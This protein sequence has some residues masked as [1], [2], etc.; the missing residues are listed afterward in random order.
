MVAMDPNGI[1]FQRAKYEA[2][3]YG[4]DEW[5]FLRELV[6]NSRDAGATSVSFTFQQHGDRET[7]TCF[8]DGT[9]MSRDAMESY[10]LKLYSSSKE[11]PTDEAQEQLGF[12]G[13][14]F[15]SVLRFKPRLIEVCSRHQGTETAIRILPS[16]HDIDEIEPV[17]ASKLPQGTRIV[18]TRSLSGSD[19]RTLIRK[20]LR[21]YARFIEACPVHHGKNN[22]PS[23][24]L[25]FNGETL[26]EPFHQKKDLVFTRESTWKCSIYSSRQA[27]FQIYHGGLLIHSCSRIDEVFVNRTSPPLIFNPGIRLSLDHATPLMDRKTIFEDPAT[28]AILEIVDQAC[29][30]I[31]DQMISSRY[32]LGIRT[33]KARFQ[34]VFSYGVLC[35]F[36]LVALFIAGM[37][38][39]H[40]TAALPSSPMNTQDVTSI[41][42]TPSDTPRE[43]EHRWS[44]TYRIRGT[45]LNDPVLFTLGLLDQNN[46]KPRAIPAWSEM[47]SHPPSELHTEDQFIDLEL[48]VRPTQK[49]F[50][51]PAPPGYI[52]LPNSPITLSG[53]PF[54]SIRWDGQCSAYAL[55]SMDGVLKYTLQKA[56][57]SDPVPPV[58]EYKPQKSLF[59]IPELD[60]FVQ[61]TQP[62]S[63]S[64]KLRATNLLFQ[65]YFHYNPI[66]STQP[67]TGQTASWPKQL[68]ESGRGVCD[69]INGLGALILTRL[70][71]KHQLQYGIVGMA[72]RAEPD[73]HAWIVRGS[74][75]N[76]IIDF[77]AVLDPSQPDLS[78][79][80]EAEQ[81]NTPP[82]T[83][84]ARTQ[85]KTS[86][87]SQYVFSYA[88]TCSLIV[89]FLAAAFLF[90]KRRKKKS[91][92]DTPP[93][94]LADMIRY[95]LEHPASDPLLLKLRPFFT[96]LSGKRLCLNDF[97]RLSPNRFILLNPK[98]APLLKGIHPGIH[99][100]DETH[101]FFSA[102]RGFLPDLFQLTGAIDSQN[103]HEALK[104]IFRNLAPGSELVVLE[105]EKGF[106]TFKLPLSSAG[107]GNTQ[108]VLGSLSLPASVRQST[109]S[110]RQIADFLH[111]LIQRVEG[112]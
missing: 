50:R 77:T 19:P 88:L 112:D 45:R 73:L 104:N 103:T 57:I 1:F 33:L 97:F 14:G 60:S 22:R 110:R 100:M 101:P 2:M 94:Q 29:L 20:K 30:D 99:L 106:H 31:Q 55:F 3:R 93:Q 61:K 36:L 98:H 51:L 40:R 65:K 69:E 12:F 92:P 25:S 83:H 74:S 32:P 87:K 16:N 11:A 75:L 85:E 49:P 108:F 53:E 47:R 38:H 35:L 27:S 78:G 95:Q 17:W 86:N 9:G 56:E 7:L 24:K 58:H 89:L 84:P 70:N 81:K 111:S 28:L 62:L 96:T 105:G 79:H 46:L 21:Y 59:E 68:W 43:T 64:E 10:L 72:G 37:K 54:Q 42:L 13:V 90:V 15:W 66:V 4:D 52:F 5:V 41:V 71:M 76:Q 91:L 34:P 8:D 44:F 6:Q 26:N 39:T 18:L 67:S 102:M 48:F 80:R 107:L 109:A 82:V 23:L 63:P